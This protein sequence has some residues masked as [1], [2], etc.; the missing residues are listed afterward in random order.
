MLEMVGNNKGQM[1]TTLF[2]ILKR[3]GG[4]IETGIAK[5]FERKGVI[6][7]SKEEAA[8]DAGMT[9]TFNFG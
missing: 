7:I 9:Q 1:Q 2:T 5:M 4:I 6:V 8:V 3:N